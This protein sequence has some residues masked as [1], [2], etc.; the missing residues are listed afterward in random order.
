MLPPCPW[1]A[2]IAGAFPDALAFEGGMIMASRE[3]PSMVHF[4]T[5]AFAGG[6]AKHTNRHI[7]TASVKR[8]R[9]CR[10]MDRNPPVCAREPKHDDRE[11]TSLRMLHLP[12][13]DSNLLCY[14]L[15]WLIDRSQ[16]TGAAWYHK[17]GIINSDLQRSK[18]A[19]T[20]DMGSLRKRVPGDET[21]FMRH[22]CV[23]PRARPGSGYPA[24]PPVPIV[25][26]NVL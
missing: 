12:N 26:L 19:S 16:S 10:V 8:I 5:C 13:L 11:K 2:N 15:P 4:I 21:Y 6:A 7:T 14:Y 24:S 1:K 9:A 3:T 22:V 17:L 25:F 18:R 20:C 23:K